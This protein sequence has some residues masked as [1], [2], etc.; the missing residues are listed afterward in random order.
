M[1]T[2]LGDFQLQYVIHVGIVRVHER[3][4]EK[5]ETKVAHLV[6]VKHYLRVPDIVELLDGQPVFNQVQ[7][8]PVAVVVVTCV[9]LVNERRRRTLIGRAQSVLIPVHNQIQTVWIKGRHKQQDDVLQYL[10]DPIVFPRL[11]FVNELG[12]HLGCP[13]LGRVNGTGDH[14]DG[15][16]LGNQGLGILGVKSSRVGQ[17]GL[18]VPILV[19]ITEVLR[20]RHGEVVERSTLGAFPHIHNANPAGSVSKH[21]VICCELAPIGEFPVLAGSKT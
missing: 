9:F 19:K 21:P 12:R 17:T 7:H 4:E 20:R 15:L 8:E 14:D 18:D 2:Q 10:F 16:P 1:D 11:Q 3:R 5:S 6:E 13:Y